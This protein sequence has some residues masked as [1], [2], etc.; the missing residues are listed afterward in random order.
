MKQKESLEQLERSL[1]KK[2]I[3]AN[4]A[5]NKGQTTHHGNLLLEINLL[6]SKIRKLSMGSR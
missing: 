1:K 5:K 4:D 3:E 2:E 6:K